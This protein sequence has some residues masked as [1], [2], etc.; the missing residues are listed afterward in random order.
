MFSVPS[1]SLV[2]KV[3]FV[4]PPPE[5]KVVVVVVVVVVGIVVV[6]VVGVVVVVVVDVVVVSGVD[7]V[8]V[9][10]VMVLVGLVVVV[11]AVGVVVVVVVDEPKCV[12]VGVTVVVV[13]VVASVV[14]PGGNA[15]VPVVMVGAE[16]EV[17]VVEGDDECECA[18]KSL[19]S[20]VKLCRCL[21]GLIVE[22]LTSHNVASKTLWAAIHAAMW[23]MKVGSS[24]PDVT[25]PEFET[26]VAF[27][28]VPCSD[29]PPGNGDRLSLLRRERG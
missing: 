29:S 15:A 7:G 20:V 4:Q 28:R 1:A 10:V 25:L 16:V 2:V 27:V 17:E 19:I 23:L 22:A 26:R 24:P 18:Q 9:G 14:V 5:G 13:V 11:V 21:V 8:V 12:V 6:V 3:G